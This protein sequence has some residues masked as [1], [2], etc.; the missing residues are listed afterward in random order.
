M[1]NKRLFLAIKLPKELK[2]NLLVYQKNH[3]GSSIFKKVGEQNLHLTILFIGQVQE[4]QISLVEEVIAREVKRVRVPNINFQMIE[5]GPYYSHPRLVWLKGDYNSN[6]EKLRDNLVA[7][8]LGL[9]ILIPMQKTDFVP[10]ITL[11]RIRQYSSFPLPPT[12]Q[13][14]QPLP[15]SFVPS[16]AWLIE[17]HLSVKG[18]EYLDLAQFKFA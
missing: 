2:E 1:I 7:E 13:I 17:S 4:S 5:Y 16:S 8:L 6:L 15:F 11:A 3:L 10:H 12:Q 9:N 14:V 18:A